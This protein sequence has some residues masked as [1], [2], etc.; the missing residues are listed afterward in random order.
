MHPQAHGRHLVLRQRAGLVGADRRGGTQRLDRGEFADQ[1][2]ALDH[3]AHAEGQ[4]DRDDGGQTFRHGGDGQADGDQK[5]LD[6]LVLKLLEV[7]A[8]TAV[9]GED[10]TE[11]GIAHDG[12]D[13]HQRADHQRRQA[14][15][16]AQLIEFLLQ[17]GRFFFK[18]LDHLGDQADL[19]GHARAGDDAFAAAIRHHRAHVGRVLAVAQRRFFLQRHAGFFLDGVRFARQRRFVDLEV[20]AFDQA[21]IGGDEVARFEQHHIAGHELASGEFLPVAVAD[22]IGF[23]RG[24]LFQR[25]QGGLGAAFLHHA[26]HRIQHHNRH[27]DD[28]L[29]PVAQQRGDD[30]GGDQQHDDKTV[31]LGHDQFPK[32][33]GG[34]LAEFVGAEPIQSGLGFDRRQA[35]IQF[36]LEL[37]GDGFNRWLCHGIWGS[38]TDIIRSVMGISRS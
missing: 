3:L 30:A 14:Q 1:R 20:D 22:H 23:G 27:D 33:R 11:V 5:R 15:R 10:Q 24:H 21:Q 32:R 12:D 7:R 36:G 19:R 35:R 2:V 6:Q 29:H 38:L 26:Q 34:F 4:A 18:R 28:G 31:E 8:Q 9:G 37:R 13:E 25:G 16:L 17:R